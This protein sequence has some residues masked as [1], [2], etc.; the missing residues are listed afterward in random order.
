MLAHL[1][2]DVFVTLDSYN[3]HLPWKCSGIVPIHCPWILRTVR[4]IYSFA[5]LSLLCIA[6]GAGG[7]GFRV[8][9]VAGK[10]TF[11]HLPVLTDFYRQIG[12]KLKCAGQFQRDGYNNQSPLFTLFGTEK[13]RGNET[14]HILFKHQILFLNCTDWYDL[15]SALP[16]LYFS[17]F[18]KLVTDITD[19]PPLRGWVMFTLRIFWIWGSWWLVLVPK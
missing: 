17:W 10:W 19:M 6:M 16:F 3:L 18:S 2:C 1:S 4:N 11:C 14:K 13:K 12:I 7:T 15:I 9:S 5:L 8:K